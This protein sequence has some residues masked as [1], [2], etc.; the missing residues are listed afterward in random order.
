MKVAA[1]LP[2]KGSSQRIEN[3]NIK[4]LAGKSLFMHTL[5]KLASCDFIDEVYLDSE[6]PL[7]FEM[8]ENVECRHFIRDKSLADNSTD[9]HAL[10]YNQIKNVDAD[11]YIQI[12]ATSPFIT[13]ETIKK[14]VDI[15][16]NSQEY[17]SVVLVKKEK[18][19]LWENGQPLYDKNNIP[20]SFELNDT[21]IET[22]GLY[23]VK[24]ETA[25][26]YKRRFGENVYL[27]KASP[28]EAIDIN[29]PEDFEIAELIALGQAQKEIIKF[30]SLKNY[31]TS[32]VLSDVLDK[33]SIKGV[34]QGLKPNINNSKL[35]GRAKTLRLGELKHTEDNV[36]NALKSYD[37]IIP[38]DVIAVQNELPDFAYFG[39]INANLAI[40]Q[41]AVGA[42][43]TGNTRDSEEVKR[44]N[45]PVFSK[46]LNCADLKNTAGVISINKVLNIGEILIYPGDLIFA[47]IEGV[48]VIP[49]K[50]SD[51]IINEAIN[52]VFR[53]KILI[54]DILEGLETSELPRV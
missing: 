46:G 34:I 22:M 12:L 15:L 40:R 29:T 53:E 47:D 51:I 37:S 25:F 43:I 6:S 14:G 44:L 19:Y 1:F 4:L 21:C 33:Y 9:G 8:A 13:K 24:K 54:K 35:L 11:I 2:A 49:S 5:E 32:P 30:N 36:Y 17:D 48:V 20:N 18:L 26:N 3:K 38:G 28:L 7:I 42:V 27:L 41:G 52:E 10:F 50:I 39:E 45:F 23:I 31:L 16:K